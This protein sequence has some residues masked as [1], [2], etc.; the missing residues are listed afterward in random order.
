VTPCSH[1]EKFAAVQISTSTSTA[2]TT[3]GCELQLTGYTRPE[4]ELT[5]L[6]ERLR[7]ETA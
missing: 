2:T 6:L 5:L 3:D 1:I 4:P 7:L